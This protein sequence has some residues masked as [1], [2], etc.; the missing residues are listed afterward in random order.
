M[1]A[2]SVQYVTTSDGYRIA[3]GVSGSGPPLV[4]LPL[5][6]SHVQMNW[7]H[8][9]FIPS[10]RPMLEALATRFQLFQF[11][12]RGQGMSSRNLR[13]DFV[14][15]HYDLD[16]E[17]LI[18]HLG[19]DQFV[20]L[21]AFPRTTHVA[22]RYAIKH[23]ERVRA[24]VLIS[25]S[26]SNDG[27]AA[28]L[29]REFP[30]GNWEYFLRTQLA[31]GL[32]PTE[33]TT[34]VELLKETTNQAD[35]TLMARQWTG[36]GIGNLPA[37][38]QTPALVLHP[39]DFKLVSAEESMALAAMIPAARM[40]M[41]DGSSIYGDAQQA[42]DAIGD[43]LAHLPGNQAAAA[44]PNAG[45]SSREVEVLRLLAAGK[46]NQQIADE[47]V[48]SLNTVRRHVSNV[49]DKTGVANRAQAT[50]YAKDHGIA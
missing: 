13:D 11:D 9:L 14:V 6:F 7:Q 30:S 26:S 35:F 5:S 45:L 3:Y 22:I 27:S 15:E 33:V 8:S 25:C 38:L 43:F 10:R 40:Q 20:V 39:R 29:F 49:F 44:D 18:E 19:L 36:A 4:F 34:G 21:A 24:L 48:I 2:P 37:S 32:S 23:P 47:L 41:I 46:S 28:G 17:A 42:L 16:L 12:S 31:Q 50:A 1:E